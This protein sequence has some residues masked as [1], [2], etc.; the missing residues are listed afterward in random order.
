MNKANFLVVVAAIIE[1]DRGEILLIKRSP[2]S[3]LPNCW[4]DAGGH[5]KQSESPEDGLRREIEEETGIK[6]IEIIKPLTVFHVYKKD[7]KKEGKQLIGI[8]YWCKTTTSN[9]TLSHEHTDFKWIKP[10][11]AI[12]IVGHPAVKGYISIYLQEKELAVKVDL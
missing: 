8:S 12:E 7:I 6:D 2:D 11:Q 4:E 3:E 10:E 1:N 9:I 5:L